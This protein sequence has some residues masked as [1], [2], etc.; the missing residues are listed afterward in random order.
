MG[1]IGGSGNQITNETGDRIQGNK[2]DTINQSGSFG[3]GVNKGTINAHNIAGN[4]NQSQDETLQLIESLRQQIQTLETPVVGEN[5]GFVSPGA[6][7]G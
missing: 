5:I 1:S 4:I 3:V 7:C 6:V 2:G